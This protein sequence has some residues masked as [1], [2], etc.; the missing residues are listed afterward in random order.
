[1]GD[2][3]DIEILGNILLIA[4]GILGYW[5]KKSMEKGLNG[6]KVELTNINSNINKLS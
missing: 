3:I 4:I 1:M 6:I 2:G 5:I